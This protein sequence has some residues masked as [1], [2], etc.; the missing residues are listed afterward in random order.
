MAPLVK[1]LARHSDLI[2]SKV[3]VTAQHRDMLDQVLRDFDIKSDYD[4]DVMR[5]NQ[6]LAHTTQSVLERMTP[7]LESERPDIVL[8]HGDT[9]TTASAALAAYYLRIPCGH[10]EAGLRT[11]DKYAP[12]PEEIMR[13][14]ADAISDIHFAPTQWAK[15]NLLKEGIPEESIFVTGNTAVDTLLLT[16]KDDYVFKDE[17]LNRIDF[18]S[19]KNIVVEVH[20]R[21]NFGQGMENVAEALF[22]IAEKRHDVQLL[23]SVH[24]NPNA[25]EPIMRHLSNAPRTVLFDPLDYPDYVNLVKRSY[26][27]ISDSGGIQEEAPSLGVPVVL[28]RDKTERP[29]AVSAGTVAIVGTNKDLIVDTVLDLLENSERYE[30]MSKARNP[31][32][33]GR[34]SLRI[35]QALMY[36]F[37]LTCEKPCEFQG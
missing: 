30:K 25:R 7:V 6:T 10:V 9:V 15:E 19:R 17:T 13:K 14:I 33:D 21:E 32:G 16:A 8:V 37:G 27:V 35:V 5:E 34:A 24:R 26:L 12:F 18:Q 36:W 31:F 3:L 22:A 4:L 11:G 2:D 28:C 1:E 29:E 23:V 20:R